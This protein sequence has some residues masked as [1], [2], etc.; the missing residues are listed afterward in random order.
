MPGI[1]MDIV[2]TTIDPDTPRADVVCAR[3][4]RYDSVYIYHNAR[5]RGA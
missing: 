3:S 2:I 5:R 1:Y 4:I